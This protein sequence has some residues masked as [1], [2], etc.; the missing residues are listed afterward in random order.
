MGDIRRHTRTRVTSV[1]RAV[2][3]VLKKAIV[4]RAKVSKSTKRRRANG[5]VTPVCSY[6]QRGNITQNSAAAKVTAAAE[7][8]YA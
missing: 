8:C 1:P 4:E 2:A 3:T 7:V 5:H 6:I